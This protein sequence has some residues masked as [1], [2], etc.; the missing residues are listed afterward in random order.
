M[1]SC[2]QIGIIAN[3]KIRTRIAE[4]QTMGMFFLWMHQE[5]FAGS[6]GFSLLSELHSCGEHRCS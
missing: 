5:Q 4:S 1:T 3:T 2:G 6:K